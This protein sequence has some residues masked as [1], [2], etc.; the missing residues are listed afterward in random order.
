MSI[1]CQFIGPQGRASGLLG[2]AIS[3]HAR[4]VSVHS[5]IMNL[6]SGL[7]AMR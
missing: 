7:A 2:Q 3:P 4:F 1:D 5:F 6:K